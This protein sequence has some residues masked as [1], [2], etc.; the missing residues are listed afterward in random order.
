MTDDDLRAAFEKY[1][2]IV[3]CNVVKD[4]ISKQ[5]REFGFVKYGSKDV[6]EKAVREMNETILVG[7][8][9][10]VEV[11]RRNEPRRQTPGKYLGSSNYR[12]N[13]RPRRRND[14]NDS[15]DRGRRREGYGREREDR[16][17]PRD[18]RYKREYR[19]RKDSDHTREDRERPKRNERQIE[20][21][22]KSD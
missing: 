10:K 3:S 7:K 2:D 12:D 22:N 20:S 15:D 6:V 21:D 13:D 8:K 11:S 5:S 4:H 16:Y 19:P 17:R 18:D 9:I 14:S 1:G